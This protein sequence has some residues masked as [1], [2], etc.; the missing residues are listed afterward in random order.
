MCVVHVHIHHTYIY[1]LHTYMYMYVHTFGTYI[2]E[3]C[4]LHECMYL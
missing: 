3:M 2:H 4:T 1:T